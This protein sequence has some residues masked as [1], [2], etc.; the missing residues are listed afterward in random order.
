MNRQENDTWYGVAMGLA[1]GVPLAYAAYKIYDLFLPAVPIV[2]PGQVIG[3]V[4]ATAGAIGAAELLKKRKERRIDWRVER[5]FDLVFRKDL[6]RPKRVKARTKG[7]ITTLDYLIPL[8]YE[9]KDFYDNKGELEQAAGGQVELEAKGNFLKMVV[10]HGQL[11]NRI[12]YETQPR[13][14]KSY[15]MLALGHSV[16][17]VEWWDIKKDPHLLCG[18]TTGGGKTTFLKYLTMQ[19]LENYTAAEAQIV[20]IDPKGVD[21]PQFGKLDR[22]KLAIELD[23]AEEMLGRVQAEM[24]F[25]LR[26]FVENDCVDIF[27]FNAKVEQLPFVFCIID[28]FAEFKKPMVKIT[29]RLLRLGRAAGV[30]LVPT[31]QRPDA[32]VFPGG[33][34]ANVSAT[35]AFKCRDEVNSRIL[36]GNGKAYMLPKIKGRGILQTD[37]DW[38]IQVPYVSPEYI[39]GYVDRYIQTSDQSIIQTKEQ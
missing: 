24:D 21:F 33:L 36:L 22:V 38:Q 6:P 18:S 37:G 11:L 32:E 5:V 15:P 26:L 8:G 7:N 12:E 9:L 19:L 4:G 16:R 1:Q 35:I 25:R 2:S 39:Q 28:E 13:P 17:G 23:D 14:K 30:A 31:T 34:K 27:Q 20:I 10:Y 29:E 3:A